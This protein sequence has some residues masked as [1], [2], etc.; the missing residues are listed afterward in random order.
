[1]VDE[2]EGRA[3]LVWRLAGQ[4]VFSQTSKVQKVDSAILMQVFGDC[5]LWAG[6]E[7]AMSKH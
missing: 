7:P 4:P 2:G 3:W 1:M 6:P 5:A